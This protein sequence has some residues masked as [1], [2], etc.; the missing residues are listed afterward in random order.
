MLHQYMAEQKSNSASLAL[1][2]GFL[3][4]W[5]VPL[6]GHIGYIHKHMWIVY[7]SGGLQRTGRPQHCIGAL[8]KREEAGWKESRG[9]MIV[10]PDHVRKE[11]GL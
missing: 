11:F 5:V 2:P 4:S 7:K 6:I 3:T 9:Q 1:Q 8:E 10:S